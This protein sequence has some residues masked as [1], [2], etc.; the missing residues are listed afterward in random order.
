MT[1]IA[2]IIGTLFWLVVFLGFMVTFFVL[3]KG[4][5]EGQAL[6]EGGLAILIMIALGA[7]LA[8]LARK[9]SSQVVSKSENP[10]DEAPNRGKGN[11]RVKRRQH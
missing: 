5:F 9:L 11:H 8:L 3:L 1:A 10:S 2:M 7:P 4:G 6:V